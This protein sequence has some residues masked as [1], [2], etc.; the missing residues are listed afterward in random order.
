MSREAARAIRH[1][2]AEPRPSHGTVRWRSH[3]LDRAVA[4]E[5]AWQQLPRGEV[6]VLRQY[7]REVGIARQARAEV[8]QL[9]AASPTPEALERQIWDHAETIRRRSLPLLES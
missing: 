1:H 9:T 3:G 8:L 5:K 2:F 4:E 6:Q 7:R